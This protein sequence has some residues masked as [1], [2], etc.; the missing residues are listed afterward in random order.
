MPTYGYT[1]RTTLCEHPNLF[2]PH[3]YVFALWRE[4]EKREGTHPDARRACTLHTERP[5]TEKGTHNL[6]T[7]LNHCA[8]LSAAA[9]SHSDSPVKPR[10]GVVHCYAGVRACAFFCLWL[11]DGPAHLPASLPDC[12]A[13]AVSHR[14][15][16]LL[17]VAAASKPPPLLP[18]ASPPPPQK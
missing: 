13:T 9:C 14:C 8:L 17:F 15:L 12:V 4:A 3:M 7:G 5:Q 16:L 11:S 1:S 6:L 2:S 18:S 10:R